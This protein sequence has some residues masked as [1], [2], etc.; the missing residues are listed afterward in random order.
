VVHY[1]GGEGVAPHID[2]KDAT[3]LCY[4]N[5]VPVNCGG[6]TV[7]V[8]QTVADCCSVLQCVAVRCHSFELLQ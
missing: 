8:L 3:L 6:R 7:C 5:D 4:L 2:G 1:V